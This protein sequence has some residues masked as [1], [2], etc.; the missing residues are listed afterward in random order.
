[1]SSKETAG[2]ARK[3]PSPRGNPVPSAPALPLA[4]TKRPHIIAVVI[5]SLYAAALMFQR[6]TVPPGMNSDVAEEAL[7]GIYLV[8]GHHFEV[9]T[10]SVGNSAETLYLYLVGIAAQVFGPTTLAIQFVGWLFGLACVWL[11]WKLVERIADV[12]AWVPLLTGAC[13]LWLFH[14]ARNGLRAISAPVFLGA[15]ALLL[16]R[17][18]RPNA[19]RG[20]A[21]LSGAVLGLSIYGYTSAR[22]LP[23]AFLAYA[24]YRLI[25][26]AGQFAQLLLRY[27]TVVAGALFTSIP[28]L[29]F[30]AYHPKEFLFRGDYVMNGGAADYALQLM[31]SVLFPVF[32]S[33]HFRHIVIAGYRSDGVATGLTSAGHNPL[34][35][36][37]A[38]AFLIGVW[39]LKDW[40]AKPLMVFL[41]CT[42]IVATLALGIA[43]PSPTR[44]LILL[45][46]YL[47]IA[48][49]GFGWVLVRLPKM[50]IAVLALI[51]V[52]GAIDGYTYF[53]GA[54]E[55]A[56][57]RLS[58]DPAPVAIGERAEQLASQGRRVMCIVS[59]DYNVVNYLT[60]RYS[61]KVKIVESLFRRIDP[62]RVPLNEFRPDI[63]LIQD[64]DR[65]LPF[66][67]QI[68]KD[69]LVGDEGRF[70][71]W[72]VPAR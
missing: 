32:Y 63:M 71:E 38:V 44:L 42:W 52:A 59:R 10:F 67:A 58:Y 61:S 15:F 14:Y 2:S 69:W 3:R 39:R 19:G 28:N 4:Q 1:M 29:V 17:A 34:Q 56:D 6:G 72:R 22:A 40:I 45:P 8:E 25:R 64:Y 30:F 5:L 7:R 49:L 13:S 18:E 33:D 35:I 51:L 57:Y 31:W 23:L 9:I 27:A 55:G 37:F 43:G 26:S 48:S 16:E 70:T 12:P 24:A 60:H 65:F 36:V 41:V 68:P 53:S 66:I 62:A 21:F 20:A 54:G 11:I 46:V 47:V 50:R